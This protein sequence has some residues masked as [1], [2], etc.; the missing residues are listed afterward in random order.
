ML[1]LKQQTFV[2]ILFY[3]HLRI[4]DDF[5]YFLKII[6]MSSRHVY[7]DRLC[8]GHHETVLWGPFRHSISCYFYVINWQGPALDYGLTSHER[9]ECAYE[10]SKIYS[11]HMPTA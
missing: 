11:L 4:A 7:L 2:G 9:R 8:L 5:T 6:G 10:V 3:G 1:S